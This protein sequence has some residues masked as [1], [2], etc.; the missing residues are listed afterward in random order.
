MNIG[1]RKLGD[2]NQLVKFDNYKD[3]GKWNVK[4][5]IDKQ[6]TESCSKVISAKHCGKN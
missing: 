3:Q 5:L 4:D 6:I 1:S 2:T